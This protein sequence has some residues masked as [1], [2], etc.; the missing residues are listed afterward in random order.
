[1]RVL[2]AQTPDF[3]PTTIKLI[4]PT[5]LL[6]LGAIIK[7]S[8]HEVE[9]IDPIFEGMSTRQFVDAVV[10][11]A[12]DVFGMYVPSDTYFG[13]ARI[14]SA[15]KQ[16]NPR[17]LT[18]AGGP[19]PTL[20]AESILQHLPALD[21]AVR[22]DAEVMLPLLLDR[23]AHGASLRGVPNV[24]F[25]E[26]GQIVD[27]KTWQPVTELDGYPFPDYTLVDINAYGFSHSVNGADHKAMNII[28][29]R[30]CPYDCLFC[31]NTNLTQRMV[32]Y[33][34]IPR[35]VDEIEHLVSQYGVS[36]IWIQDDAFNLSQRRVL[37]FCDE[38]ERRQLRIHWSCIMR[39]DNAT[40][41]LLGRMKDVGFTG[42]YFA[43]EHVV[44]SLRQDVL[45]KN[46]EMAQAER[47][48]AAFN[49]LN[50]WCGI[51]FIISLPDE[52]R[53]DMEQNIAYI[54]GLK[55]THKQS[56]VALNLLKIYPGTRLELEARRRGILRKGFSWF[57]ERKLRRYS[58][59]VLPGLYGTIPFYR[60]HIPGRE[61]FCALFR[62]R[63]T[64]WFPYDPNKS[65]SLLYYL[66]CY[67]GNIK[68]L[69]DIRLLGEALLGWLMA[70]F[71][72]VSV[73][74]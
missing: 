4:P 73:V 40:R 1:M 2:L 53:A 51:N 23:L 46:L 66:K 34:A 45:G 20:L 42:G 13:A 28:T 72:R 18:M 12:P 11:R 43:I 15:V 65:S 21:M 44:D 33:R 32:R 56:M 27:A 64:R 17:I 67:L 61:L 14:F 5:V 41:E 7:R 29:A 22:G 38:V 69:K 57:D 10:R 39:A 60:E 52:T 74:R 49:E 47:A 16:R 24:S 59:G 70:C 19:H 6:Y 58:P 50:L 37:Q 71:R 36:F 68:G 48:I 25:R 55:L 35:V 26:W 62:W 9:I 8:G 31:S 54:E 30:G 3:F 63:R